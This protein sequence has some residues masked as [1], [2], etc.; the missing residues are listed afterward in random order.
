MSKFQKYLEAVTKN[1]M[2][3]S[4][5]YKKIAEIDVANVKKETIKKALESKFQGSWEIQPLIVDNE[6]VAYIGLLEKQNLLAKLTNDSKTIKIY[7]VKSVDKDRAKKMFDLQQENPT[8][9]IFN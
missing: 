2:K 7:N 4:S 9:Q 1:D 3:E 6:I 8:Y 5:I